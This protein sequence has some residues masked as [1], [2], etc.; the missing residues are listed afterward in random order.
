MIAFALAWLSF[1]AW[2]GLTFT[3][4]ERLAPRVRY[5]VPASKIVVASML[6]AA[7][8]VLARLI[9]WTPES[10][11]VVRIA[12]GWFVTELLMYW[13]HRAQHAVPWLWRF[14]RL[15]HRDEPLAWATAWYSHPVDT[16]L[17]AGCALVGG[18]ACGAGAPASALFVMVRRAWTVLLHA[19]VRWPASALD[20]VVATPPFHHRHHI[21][22]L[23]PAN[24]ASTLPVLDRWFGTFA[25]AARHLPSDP[26]IA[27]KIDTQDGG[28]FAA[29]KQPSPRS[30]R[31]YAATSCTSTPSSRTSIVRTAR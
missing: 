11:A 29:C 27:F 26:A 6:L 15:H 18:L 7:E 19:N 5:R 2:S 25:A 8:A 17:F 12:A 14:H 16:A 22:D 13:V 1:V 30:R 10:G 31:G 28:S 20:V 3:A 23:A 21:E 4:L 9:I 24:F